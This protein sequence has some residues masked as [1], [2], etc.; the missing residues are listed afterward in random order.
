MYQTIL[1]D[2]SKERKATLDFSEKEAEM[3]R[4]VTS[5]SNP[6]SSA[7]ESRT[8]KTRKKVSESST[9]DVAERL[10]KM[11]E[12]YNEKRLIM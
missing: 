4:T 9:S 2:Y 8:P 11:G 12:M 3:P 1:K 7:G 6:I 10:T 5:N